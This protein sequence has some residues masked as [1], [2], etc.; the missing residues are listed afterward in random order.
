MKLTIIQDIIHWAD[1]QS[2][3]DKTQEQLETLAGKTDLVILPEMFSTGF[4]TNHPELAEDMEENT[5]K[6]LKKWALNYGLAIAGSFIATENGKLYNRGFFVFQNGEIATADKRHLFSMGGEDRFFSAGNDKLTVSYQG[7]NIRLLICYD[8]RF[9]VWSRNVN[10]EY[11]LLIYVANFPKSRISSWDILLPARAVENQAY[12]CG[13]NCIGTDGNG[14][15]YNGHSALFDF[16]GNKTASAPDNETSIIT[17][18]I[19][20]EK[21][22]KFRQKAAFWKDADNFTINL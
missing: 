3:L 5:V 2:N 9:P 10:N 20:K 15:E 12:V 18:E 16:K 6:T 7:F 4:C 13:V 11:D 14:I 1:K 8:V 17:T 22:D 19:L 21:L